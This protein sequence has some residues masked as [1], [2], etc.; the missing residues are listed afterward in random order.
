MAD[1]KNSTIGFV[2]GTLVGVAG[3]TAVAQSTQT[4]PPT[5]PGM[6]CR[7]IGPTNNPVRICRPVLKE[8]AKK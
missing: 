8:A 4:P 7:M 5:P 2:V 3:T 1:M 6:D